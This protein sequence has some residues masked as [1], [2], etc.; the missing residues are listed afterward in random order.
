MPYL[1]NCKDVPDSENLRQESKAAHFAYIESI[2]D[3]LLVAGPLREEP[4]GPAVG[5]CFIY[6]SDD[7]GKALQLL[8]DDPYFQAGVWQKTDGQ[9]FLAAAG[10]WVGGASWKSTDAD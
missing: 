3:E 5:S 10:S 6:R 8:H 7:Y 4:D 2:M 1:F 9:Y